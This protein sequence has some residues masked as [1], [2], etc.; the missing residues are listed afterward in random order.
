[1]R[2]QNLSRE[3][4]HLTHAD[5][6]QLAEFMRA[7]LGTADKLLNP[8]PPPKPDPDQVL[9]KFVTGFAGRPTSTNYKMITAYGKGDVAGFGPAEAELLI[10]LGVAE[11]WIAPHP[12]DGETEAA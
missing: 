2:A 10:K 12:P 11:R 3:L 4:G 8:P 5:F 1:V 9:V 7:R 6:P